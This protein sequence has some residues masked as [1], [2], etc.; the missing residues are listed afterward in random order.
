M[1]VSII[2]AVYNRV[3]TISHTLESVLEQTHPDIEYI[4]VDGMSNDGTESI[5]SKY[6]DR[7]DKQVREKDQGIY[8][9]LNK[10]IR[11]ASGDVV[12]LL[13]ADDFFAHRDVVANI[14]QEFSAD[15]STMG[16]YGD[17]VYVD[18]HEPT[19]TVRRWKSGDYEVSKYRWGW[20]PPHPTV[21]LRR[22]CYLRHGLFRDDLH[23]AADYELLL[24]MMLVNGVPMRY[25]PQILV[26]MRVGG[27]SNA[28]VSNRM[29][30]NREDAN[31]WSVNG[32]R[33]PWAL[34]LLKPLRKI[35]QYF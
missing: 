15:H 6:S 7:I 30:A 32:L 10:G 11:M 28:S 34:R 25:I 17:L 31:A 22:E 19:R 9:A 27:L 1:K 21:Y 5:V 16:V 26:C 18:R 33:P 20:M 23:F 4:V 24:R 13:H 35:Y 2:T 3:E 12:G 29:Q 8:D 14:A